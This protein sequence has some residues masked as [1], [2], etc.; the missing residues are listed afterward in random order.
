MGRHISKTKA[1]TKINLNNNT[2]VRGHRKLF[3]GEMKIP[4][5][6]MLH[7]EHLGYASIFERDLFLEFKNG[8]LTGSREVDNTKTFD[9]DDPVDWK[10]DIKDFI[11]RY[12]T[13]N[14]NKEKPSNPD[15][16]SP[17]K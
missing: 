6:K 7:H 12:N 11:D 1:I 5:G 14:M 2:S 9:P 10:K 3:T 15:E 8:V 16:E 17:A 13:E 4:Q